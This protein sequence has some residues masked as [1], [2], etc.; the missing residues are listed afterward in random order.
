MI[1]QYKTNDTTNWIIYIT[2]IKEIHTIY[3]YILIIT[4]YISTNLY[5]HLNITLI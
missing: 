5:Y 2:I 4:I 3:I 1:Q